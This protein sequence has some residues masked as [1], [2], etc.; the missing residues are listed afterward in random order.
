MTSEKL[1]INGWPVWYEKFGTGPEVML[2]LPGAIGTGRSDFLPQ[3]EGQNSF[4]HDQFTI[5]AMELPGWGRSRPP[6]RPY[7]QNVYINDADVAAKLME[8]LG[9]KNYIIFCFSEGGKVGLTMSMRYPSRV[10]GLIL[11][12]IFM[13]ITPQT[14]APTL[15]TANTRNWP[16]EMRDNYLPVYGDDDLQKM[17]DGY[18]NFCKVYI[19]AFPNGYVTNK[20]QTIRCP[21][22]VFHGDLDPLVCVDHPKHVEKHVPYCQL[23]RFP[24]GTHN[25]HHKYP[26]EVKRITEQFIKECNDFR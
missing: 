7:G 20:L 24:R 21:V 25:C 19:K 6:E 5:I 22:L 16:Q 12:S 17:W 18:I 26:A 13:I 15:A 11:I 23:H 10:K 3:L 14:V 1:D 2:F 9:Y 4:D 8:T